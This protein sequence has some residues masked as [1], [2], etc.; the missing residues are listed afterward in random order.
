[1]TCYSQ[2]LFILHKVFLKT[3]DYA[4]YFIYMLVFLT[5]F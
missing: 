5:Y 4:S 1:M 3:D 2:F